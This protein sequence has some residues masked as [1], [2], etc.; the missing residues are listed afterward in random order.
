MINSIRL[1]SNDNCY[2]M[3]ASRMQHF[4]EIQT[5]GNIQVNIKDNL[6]LF[7]SEKYVNFVEGSVD[8][9]ARPA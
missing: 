1:G 7:Q 9:A 8:G 2:F 5:F 3:K 6:I 4:T